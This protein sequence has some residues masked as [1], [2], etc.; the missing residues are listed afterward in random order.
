[1]IDLKVLKKIAKECRKLGIKQFKSSEYEFTLDHVEPKKQS[2]VTK[3]KSE[4]QEAFE[5]MEEEIPGDIPSSEDLLF[6][7]SGFEQ[8]EAK[9]E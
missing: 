6:W 1:M 4:L 9:A 5:G 2:K 8:T 7:S 3:K